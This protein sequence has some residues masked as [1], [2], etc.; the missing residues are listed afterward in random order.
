[1]GGLAFLA[2]V[3]MGGALEFLVLPLGNGPGV[4]DDPRQG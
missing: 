1:M 3:V 4:R 2:G